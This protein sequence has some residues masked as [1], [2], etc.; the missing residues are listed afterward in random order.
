MISVWL[1][2]DGGETIN[3]RTNFP[4]APVVGQR[5]GFWSESDH[6]FA[7]VTEV[8][9]EQDG[10]GSFYMAVHAERSRDGARDRHGMRS[11]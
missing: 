11:V 3:L 1:L 9:F 7:T 5:L 2:V 4:A 8:G 6:V 10:D